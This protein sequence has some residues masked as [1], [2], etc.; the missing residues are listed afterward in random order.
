LPGSYGFKRR[1]GGGLVYIFL[2]SDYGK[3]L[4]RQLDFAFKSVQRPG[5]LAWFVQ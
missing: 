2:R 5:L 1:G 4:K 3:W